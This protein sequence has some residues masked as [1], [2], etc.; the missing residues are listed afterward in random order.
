MHLP[1]SQKQVDSIWK[2]LTPEQQNWITEFTNRRR[3]DQWFETLARKKGIILEAGMSEQEKRDAI[4]DWEL[5]EILDGGEGN[6]PY[7]CE[8]GKAIRYLFRVRHQKEGKTYG[9]GSTCIEHYTGLSADV[10]RDIEKGILQI[11]TERDELLIKIWK[12]ERTDL[13]K[14]INKGVDIPEC[15]I[16]QVEIGLPLLDKQINRLEEALSEILYKE[17]LERRKEKRAK[18]KENSQL[19]QKGSQF[20]QVPQNSNR[21]SNA[22]ADNKNKETDSYTYESFIAEY[23]D[24]LRKIREKED[25][26]SPRLREEWEW[27]QNEVRRLKKTGTMDFEKFLLRMNNMIIPLRIER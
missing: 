25:M 23:I 11:N 21:A 16:K 27:M 20:K 5:I 8:C 19:Q 13:S 4:D 3:R 24:I 9:L 1:M 15:I 12:N 6:R 7:R 10:V 2:L 18:L 14:Y 26:L 22:G 17:W